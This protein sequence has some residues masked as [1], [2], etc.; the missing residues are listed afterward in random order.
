MLRR[1]RPGCGCSRRC[2]RATCAKRTIYMVGRRDEE[3]RARAVCS[4]E[5]PRVGSQVSR[6]SSNAC[7]YTA[8]STAAAC[9]G[10]PQPHEAVGLLAGPRLRAAHASSCRVSRLRLLLRGSIFHCCGCIGEGPHNFPRL[11]DLT[12]EFS[13]VSRHYRSIALKILYRKDMRLV[14]R[15]PRSP[16]Q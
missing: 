10:A 15:V 12:L 11:W 1:Q 2:L 9:A 14:S 4:C 3:V 7:R 5:V 16:D 6:S 8:A 13:A